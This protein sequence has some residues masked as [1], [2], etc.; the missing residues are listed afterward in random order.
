M[1]DNIQSSRS[2][3]LSGIR[4]SNNEIGDSGDYRPCYSREL[5]K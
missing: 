3:D 5:P 1:A 4:E 2:G